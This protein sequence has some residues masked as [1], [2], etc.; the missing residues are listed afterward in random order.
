MHLCYA[1][2]HQMYILMNS[3]SSLFS[4]EY[5][6]ECLLREAVK[7]GEIEAIIE[8]I[9]IGATDFEK[10]K[11]S[12]LFSERILQTVESKIAAL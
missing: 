10:I 12:G 1:V 4:Q 2:A 9:E 3:M 7:K 8:M 11:A 6:F 5:A